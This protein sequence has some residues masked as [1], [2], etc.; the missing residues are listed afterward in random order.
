VEPDVQVTDDELSTELTIEGVEPAFFADL[1]SA[2]LTHE[3]CGTHLYRSVAGRTRDPE[4]R[5]RYEEFGRETEHHVEVLEQLVTDAGG[6]PNY[7]SPKARAVEAADAHILQ[8]TFLLSGADPM[9]EE[10]A[11]LDAV[12]LAE[13]IDQANWA[14]LAE[15]A[16]MMPEQPARDALLAAVADVE[17]DEEAHF[18]WARDARAELTLAQLGVSNSS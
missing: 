16:E 1:M 7:V 5:A 10:M 14:T 2:C 18:R 17:P 11:M 9:V 15:L 12:F 8:T 13:T 6:N 3:R 4:L